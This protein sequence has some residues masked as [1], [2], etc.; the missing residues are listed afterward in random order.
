MSDQ[1][2]FNGEY[3]QCATATSAGESPTTT[4]AKWRRIQIPKDWRLTLA[5][6]TYGHL[7]ELDGQKDKSRMELGAAREMLDE[8]VR[9]PANKEN[10]RNRPN[11]QTRC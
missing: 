10:W 5:R 3:Y 4:P 11:V 2:Y 9:L 6:L 1:A 7:L 8:K